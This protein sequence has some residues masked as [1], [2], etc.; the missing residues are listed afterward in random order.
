VVASLEAPW[1]F[2]Q[3]LAGGDL[4]AEKKGSETASVVAGN[5][6]VIWDHPGSRGVGG[7]YAYVHVCTCMSWCWAGRETSALDPRAGLECECLSLQGLG[8]G[9][10]WGVGAYQASRLQETSAVYPRTCQYLK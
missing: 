10:R 9:W 3:S 5:L 2:K 4:G 1:R 8:V 7:G 6:K